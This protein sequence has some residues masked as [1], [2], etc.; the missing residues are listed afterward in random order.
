[1]QNAP[2]IPDFLYGTAWKEDRTA[3]L[4]ELAIRSGFRGIDTA[5][6]R[7]HYFE[8]GVGQGLAAVYGSGLV[9]RADLFLQTKF[10]YLGGQDHRLPYDPSTSHSVQVAQSMASSLEHLGADYVDSLVLHG[11]ASRYGWTDDDAEVWEAMIKER[12]AG[13]ARLLGVSNI[14]LEQL[15]QMTTVHPE[16]PAFV[17]NRCYARLGW[18]RDVRR[19]CRERNII[20]QGFSLLTANLDVL[21]HSAIATL[22]AERRATP[23]QIVFA[24]AR[25]VGM[26]PLTGTSSADHMQQDLASREIVLPPDA[27]QMIE[28]LAG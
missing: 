6:Q 17:Q 21:R 1:M 7:R 9:T 19:F 15:E 12:D 25:S 13:R 20:Y 10:T 3:A 2:S 27:V 11:P 23:A 16:A 22:A 14:S 4:T 24:F 8:A 26:L 28:S 5:N 18:D